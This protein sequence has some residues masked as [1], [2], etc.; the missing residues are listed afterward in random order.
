MLCWSVNVLHC[1]NT[2]QGTRTRRS[3]VLL[4]PGQINT[5]LATAEGQLT[6]VAAA[7]SNITTLSD[8]TRS[9]SFTVNEILLERTSLKSS[10][11]FFGVMKRS[12][13][14][15]LAAQAPTEHLLSQ[16][17]SHHAGSCPAHTQ[18]CYLES[19]RGKNTRL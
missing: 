2:N 6:S 15:L 16:L 7:D 8:N 19:Q 1:V 17:D 9:R 4:S 12:L 5:S 13:L 11:T 10:L 3:C 18:R 14:W